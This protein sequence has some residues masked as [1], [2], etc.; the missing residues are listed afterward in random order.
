LDLL[1]IISWVIIRA[2]FVPRPI[3]DPEMCDAASGD[4]VSADSTGEASPPSPPPPVKRAKLDVSSP[5]PPLAR[6]PSSGKAIA[7]K[8]V[9]NYILAELKQDQPLDL[10][11]FQRQCAEIGCAPPSETEWKQLLT[12]FNQSMSRADV[13]QTHLDLLVTFLPEAAKPR[14]ER[15]AALSLRE[16]WVNCGMMA[17]VPKQSP[18]QRALTLT[19]WQ[20][21]QGDTLYR[22]HRGEDSVQ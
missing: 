11:R 13:P 2:R 18:L 4:T 17:I 14:A 7:P 3:V 5:T 21:G 20:R 16:A 9:V 8:T 12:A 19:G 1:V 22:R 6:R 15:T 10:V